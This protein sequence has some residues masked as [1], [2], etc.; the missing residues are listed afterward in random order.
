MN[1]YIISLLLGI[2]S[3]VKKNKPE[4]VREEFLELICE[5]LHSN[6]CAIYLYNSD[7]DCFILSNQYSFLRNSDYAF[8]WQ[9]YGWTLSDKVEFIDNPELSKQFSQ[10]CSFQRLLFLPLLIENKIEGVVLTGWKDICPLD[11]LTNEDYLILQHISQ[12]L[13]DVYCVHPLI[14]KLRQR[15]KDLAALYQKAEQDLEISRKEVALELHDEVGQVL[16]SILLQL[17]L[18]QQSSD[19]EY[20]KG[21]LG[22]LHHITLQTLEE[23]RRISQNLR[24]NLLEKLGLQAAVEALINDYIEN[25]GIEVELRTCNLGGRVAEELETI[26]YRSVQEGLTNVARHSGASKVIISMTIKRNNLFLQILDNGKGMKK[27]EKHGTGLLGMKERV[28]RAQGKFWIVN[29]RAQGLTINILLPLV[30]NG[31]RL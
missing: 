20:V 1:K 3:L 29:N 13:S 16:T 26:V 18:L 11:D 27:S 12:L 15:E 25:T 19:F 21:R 30:K 10:E 24:P 28:T 5:I 23:V 8:S 9:S 14:T 7:R 2:S 31:E 4:I 6:G 17:K 22:G